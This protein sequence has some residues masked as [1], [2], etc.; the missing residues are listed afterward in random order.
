MSGP[1]ACELGLGVT[2]PRRKSK[3]VTKCHK[4]FQTWMDSLDK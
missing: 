2:T 3:P 4:G 1:P